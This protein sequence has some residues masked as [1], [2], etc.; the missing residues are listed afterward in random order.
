LCSK[1]SEWGDLL[2]VTVYAKEFTVRDRTKKNGNE[3]EEIQTLDD[4][5][6][7]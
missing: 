7:K 4:K 2:P 3:S 6:E 1:N 5:I